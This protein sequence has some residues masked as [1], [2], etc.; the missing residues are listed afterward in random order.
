MIGADQVIGHLSTGVKG[1]VTGLQSRPDL[2]GSECVI[3]AFDDESGRYMIEVKPDEGPAQQLSLKP[4]NIQVS[5]TD[6]EKTV[7]NEFGENDNNSV[8]RKTSPTTQPTLAAGK[9]FIEEREGK[10]KTRE[11][12][13]WRGVWEI[14]FRKAWSHQDLR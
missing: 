12:A 2:N 3:I 13:G 14:R 6:Q 5:L 8:Q 11:T 4:A 9:K 10:R 7:E 1:R